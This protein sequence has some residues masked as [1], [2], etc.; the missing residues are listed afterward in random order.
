M[1]KQF[2][3][4][5]QALELKELGFDEECF[6]YYDA[7]NLEKYEY[8]NQINVKNSDFIF[9][10][11]AILWQQ[12]FDF[13]LNEIEDSLT[14]YNIICWCNNHK[15]ISNHVEGKIFTGTNEQCLNELIE[16]L[17]LKK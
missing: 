13:I 15:S 6:G 8:I 7:T 11:T 4:Y 17:K 14:H 9:G 10:M 16:I 12:A 2:I 1:E 5:K 3:P